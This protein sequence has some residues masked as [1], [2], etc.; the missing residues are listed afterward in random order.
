MNWNGSFNFSWPPQVILVRRSLFLGGG[1]DKEVI[2]VGGVLG[3]VL[4]ECEG[5]EGHV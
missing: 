1:K 3:M 2:S 4:V 5:E